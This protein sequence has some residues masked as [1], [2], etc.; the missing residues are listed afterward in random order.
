MSI[1]CAF[2]GNNLQLRCRFG[3]H[4]DVVEDVD[5][6]DVVNRRSR[7]PLEGKRLV[8][9]VLVSPVVVLALLPEQKNSR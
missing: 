2:R 7:D 9:V 5:E 1:D 3:I 4:V 8:V 6:V